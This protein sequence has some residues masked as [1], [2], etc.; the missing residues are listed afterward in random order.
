[1]AENDFQK[2]GP[3]LVG[4][5]PLPQS[6]EAEKAVLS[7]LLQDTAG[8]YDLIYSQLYTEDC[9]YLP[10]HRLIYT[11]I[12]DMTS[13][14]VSDLIDLVTVTDRLSRNGKLEHAG[15]DTYLN[16]ILY[17]A[18][19]TAN[20]ETYID[21]VRDSFILR[22][23]IATFTDLVGK[24]YEGQDDVGVIIDAIEEQV[25]KVSELKTETNAVAVKDLIKDAIRYLDDL[26]NQK[27]ETVGIPT[28]F[29]DLDR[30]LGGLRAG[31]MIVVAA[32][33]SIGKTTL[34]VNIAQYVATNHDIGVGVF[35]LEM[36]TNQV[37]LR[38]LCSEANINL[39]DVRDGKLTN[40]QWG[41]DIMQAGNR[42]RKAPLYIDDTPQLT[43]IELRQKARRMK[44][45]YD[46]GLVIIDY[47]QL[48]RATGGNSNTTREQE[49]SRL[50]SD[51]KALAKELNIPVM[52][53]AQMNRQAEQ[54]G[55]PKLSQLRESGAIE[56]DADVVALL[57]RDRE[58]EAG[59][60][61]EEINAGIESELIIAK[62]RNGE[63]GVVK[64]NFLMKYTKFVNLSRIPDSDVPAD[65]I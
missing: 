37:V 9:F 40:A 39:K 60:S 62:H 46:I 6:L 38:M 53:L 42:L 24:C 56:Q 50:S 12:R 19:T 47:L 23:M 59:L 15:G 14:M 5:Q 21:C 34:A 22:Q 13:E 52:V 25:R 3:L 57:H 33:P 1:M 45:D 55:K 58:T 49:V 18:P 48:M 65:Q 17:T 36:G 7:C 54:G 26:S 41:N 4:D 16:E 11:T 64:L 30:L 10:S 35:S 43:S 61:R 28:G 32:R 2:I 51:I 31:E 20:I 29:T 63:T 8:T 44:Q 27:L